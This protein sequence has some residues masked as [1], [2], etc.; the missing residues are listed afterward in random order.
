MFKIK[1]EAKLD[2]WKCADLLCVYT[3]E[4]TT[5]VNEE[6][7]A[8]EY[9][10]EFSTIGRSTSGGDAYNLPSGVYFYRLK[11]GDYFQ[12]RKMMLLK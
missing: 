4:I 12:S 8:R 2:L 3:N 10:I 5:L 11:T 7:P 6:K 9:V 1:I